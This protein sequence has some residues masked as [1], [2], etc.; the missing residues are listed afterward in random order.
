MGAKAEG[1]S[2]RRAV[3]AVAGVHSSQAA[4]LIRAA[5]D[6][7][8]IPPSSGPPP[9]DA[10]ALRQAGGEVELVPPGK[11][12]PEPELPPRVINIG[13]GEVRFTQPTEEETEDR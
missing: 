6:A 9:R 13:T 2:A 3:M 4:R 7:G 5:K 11:R 10:H 8:L 1:T 12:E